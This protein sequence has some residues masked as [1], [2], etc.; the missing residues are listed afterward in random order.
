MLPSTFLRV[1]RSYLVNMDFIRALNSKS[2]LSN[3]K[4]TGGGFLQLGECLEVPVSRRII[5]TVREFLQ[6]N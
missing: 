6:Q 5:P 1:H 2:L 3:T 4:T